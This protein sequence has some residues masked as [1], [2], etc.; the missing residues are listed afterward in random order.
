MDWDVLKLF[1]NEMI[2]VVIVQLTAYTWFQRMVRLYFVFT[3]LK[4]KNPMALNILIYFIG[5]NYLFSD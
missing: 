2:R 1:Y 4:F 5:D 3:L